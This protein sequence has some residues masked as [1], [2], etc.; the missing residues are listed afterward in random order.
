MNDIQLDLFLRNTLKFAEAIQQV[1]G[2]PKVVIPHNLDFM[3][4]LACNGIEISTQIHKGI[5]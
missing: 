1:G 2:A 5:G 3:K 4:M